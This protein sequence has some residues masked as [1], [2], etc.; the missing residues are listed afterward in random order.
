MGKGFAASWLLVESNFYDGFQ[1]PFCSQKAEGMSWGRTKDTCSERSDRLSTRPLLSSSFLTFKG[2][3]SAVF[4]TCWLVHLQKSESLLT[5]KHLQ[6]PQDICESSLRTTHS[7][8]QALYAAASL[9]L[10]YLAGSWREGERV[11]IQDR[12]WRILGSMPACARAFVWK[13]CWLPALTA[14]RYFGCFLLFLIVL[15]P[16]NSTLVISWD[17]VNASKFL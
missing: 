5:S 14:K 6:N 9:D 8:G 4:P 13:T 15:Q 1:H 11:L 7:C 3:S 12:P 2:D 17:M 16:K 10:Y